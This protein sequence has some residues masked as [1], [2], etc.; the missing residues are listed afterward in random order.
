MTAD[1]TSD[2]LLR[3]SRCDDFA[4]A[5]TSNSGVQSYDHALWLEP[6]P[7]VLA[8]STTSS[9]IGF[10]VQLG[11]SATGRTQETLVKPCHA[12]ALL[13][14]PDG[15]DGCE[16]HDEGAV[17][18]CSETL[19]IATISGES[20]SRFVAREVR[21]RTVHLH[22]PPGVLALLLPD[23]KGV[24]LE[25][26]FFA[27]DK[28]LGYLIKAFVA[29]ME[30]GGF[31]QPLVLDTYATLFANRMLE[32]E[33]KIRNEFGGLA[34]WQIRRTCDAMEAHLGQE[35]GLKELADIP[36]VSPTHFCRAFKHSTGSAPFKWLQ[37]RRIERAKEMLRTPEMTIA[38]IALAV[39]YSAQPQFTT[40]FKR[41]TGVTP[42]AWRRSHAL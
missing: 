10:L 4:G 2:R 17:R 18:Y 31:D 8:S 40:A 20:T 24:A 27:P 13:I 16:W 14:F 34:S 32:A 7:P 9:G 25:N 30:R 33:D 29:E 1:R 39:G 19:G 5:Y 11:Q 28:A 23:K 36:G 35:I 15:I 22:F 21:G 41:L 38:Q 3:A 37:S 6:P 42:A 12:D 26:R